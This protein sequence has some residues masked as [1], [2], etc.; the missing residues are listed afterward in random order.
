[1]HAAS[2]RTFC[3]VA[4]QLANVVIAGVQHEDASAAA[5]IDAGYL[6]ELSL[7]SRAARNVAVVAGRTLLDLIANCMIT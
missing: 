4:A 2:L 7:L 3:R 1:M 6:A 5:C